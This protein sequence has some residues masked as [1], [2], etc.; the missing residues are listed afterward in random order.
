[1]G[2][3]EIEPLTEEEKRELEGRRSS[4]G[5]GKEAVSPV[6]IGGGIMPLGMGRGR[7]WKLGGRWLRMWLRLVDATYFV[8][9]G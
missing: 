6:E 4:A 2:G 3:R 9:V 8:K 1:M 5:L 7:S